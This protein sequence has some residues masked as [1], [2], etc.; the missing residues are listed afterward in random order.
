M[1]DSSAPQTER[2]PEPWD[3]T[4]SA[5]QKMIVLRCLRP[6]KVPYPSTTNTRT[7]SKHGLVAEVLNLRVCEMCAKSHV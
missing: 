1:Y 4:L 3:A 5:L 2:Y 7:C 6:D